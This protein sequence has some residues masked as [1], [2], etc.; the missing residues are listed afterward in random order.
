MRNKKYIS[1]LSLAVFVVVIIGITFSNT[2]IFSTQTIDPNA[3]INKLTSIK[4]L[5][6]KDDVVLIIDKTTIKKEQFEKC[7]A[8]LTVLKN[9]PATDEEVKDKLIEDTVL[10]NEAIRRG[11]AVSLDEA[12]AFSQET[13]IAILDPK[14]ENADF[15][16]NVIVSEG[17]TIDE[18]FDTV[19]PER[20][21]KAL[22]IGKLRSQ[23]YKEIDNSSLT[24]EQRMK[25]EIDLFEKLIKE[26]KAK[27]VIQ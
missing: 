13:K 25:A 1:S 19:A 6:D 23:V 16:K 15:I 20:Y 24:P 26:L 17:Y 21:Q 18:F 14:T 27:A 7:R 22:A 10:Y 12:N 11:L 9:A 8:F 3:L 5:S 2:A 4:L